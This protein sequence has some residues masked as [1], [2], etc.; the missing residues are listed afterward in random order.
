MFIEH[1]KLLD[2]N[3]VLYEATVSFIER[4]VTERGREKERERESEIVGLLKIGE[5]LECDKMTQN[6]PK[7]LIPE[8]R[9]ENRNIIFTMLICLSKNLLWA[10]A[11][12]V[13]NYL[14]NKSQFCYPFSITL[15]IVINLTSCLFLYNATQ[16]PNSRI[17][18][19]SLENIL[20]FL[21]WCNSPWMECHL[22]ESWFMSHGLVHMVP[23]PRSL[24]SFQRLKLSFLL[25]WT[26]IWDETGICICSSAYFYVLKLNKK[27]FLSV[28][29]AFHLC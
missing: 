23:L 16:E 27:L 26:N 10:N 22:L 6:Y 2:N 19:Y 4:P 5:W 1:V 17:I 14:L 11:L 29:R 18:S 9:L 3:R 7:L 20:E 13:F 8:H 21:I 25:Q 28:K 12:Q 24:P 15:C